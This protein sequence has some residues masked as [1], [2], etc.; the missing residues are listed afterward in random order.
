MIKLNAHKNSTIQF[1]IDIKNL[2]SETLKG[3]FRLEH[4]NIEYGFPVTLLGETAKIVVPSLSTLI[5]DI[6]KDTEIDVRLDFVS[7]SEYVEAWS[8]KAIVNMPTIMEAKAE[9]V[10]E[11]DKLEVTISKEAKV[12]EEKIVPKK[13]ITMANKFKVM[14]DE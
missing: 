8:D 4:K 14:F 2:G 1:N 6:S 5:P 13:K 9:I 10:E 7:E 3:Y 11:D 12:S